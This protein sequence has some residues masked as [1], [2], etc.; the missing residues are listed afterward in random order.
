MKI[1]NFLAL[2]LI[3][4]AGTSGLN[5]CRVLFPET[6]P[7]SKVTV[8][9]IN[10]IAQ[11]ATVKY[12][13]QNIL[14]HNKERQWYEWK[15]GRILVIVQ[16][17]ITGSIKFNNENWKIEE[18]VEANNKKTLIINITIDKSS[19][20]ISDPEI[21]QDGIRIITLDDPNIFNKINDRDRDIAIN[22]AIS[23]LKN[24]ALSQ[25]IEKATAEEAKR[26]LEVF[27]ESLGY[28][29]NITITGFNQ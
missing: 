21:P 8:E 2:I 10:K 17:K 24:Q 25:G 6:V 9:Q 4:I 22:E 19:V 28:Q 29:P 13:M 18:K 12:V 20:K 5:S 11:L 14:E 1:H 16:G 27:F 15:D 26:V 7:Q 3:T 23:G